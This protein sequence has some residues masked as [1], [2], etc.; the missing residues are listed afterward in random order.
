[1]YVSLYHNCAKKST[2]K[3]ISNVA[4]PRKVKSLC[5]DKKPV[6]NSTVEVVLNYFTLYILV[7]IACTILISFDN[8]DFTTIFTSSLACIS[9]IGPGLGQVGPYGSFAN[10]SDF[11]K[12]VLSLE[13]I[14]GR[15]ELFPILVLFN[16]KTWSNRF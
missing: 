13:M 2:I 10:Y 6:S 15:L 7:L 1:M 4:N 11:S 9:N 14:A 3:K 8:F 5:I 16:P 12:L